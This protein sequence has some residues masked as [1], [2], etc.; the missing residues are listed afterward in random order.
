MSDFVTNPP[1]LL[2]AA[3]CSVFVCGE[4]Q[5]M[6]LAVRLVGVCSDLRSL[7]DLIE[8]IPQRGFGLERPDDSNHRP[9]SR[10]DRKQNEQGL[11]CVGVEAK[12]IMES[13]GAESGD[14]GSEERN[15]SDPCSAGV[16][17]VKVLAKAELKPVF[18][19]NNDIL[20]KIKMNTG[21]FDIIRREGFGELRLW[22][23]RGVTHCSLLSASQV[24][25]VHPSIP[26]RQSHEN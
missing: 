14:E 25:S 9:N 7:F 26:P 17:A 5:G 12:P 22:R 2:P 3:P 15:G 6:E 20:V 24:S 19:D 16:N 23:N 8:K 10:Y 4:K 11:P 1:P 21:L 13:A 18:G